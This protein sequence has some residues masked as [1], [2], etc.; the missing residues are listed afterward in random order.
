MTLPANASSDCGATDRAGVATD[1]PDGSSMAS[2]TIEAASQWLAAR[3]HGGF[4]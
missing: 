4:A 3:W 2:A 1:E